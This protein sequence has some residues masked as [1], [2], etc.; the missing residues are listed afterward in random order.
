MG[1][2]CCWWQAK[3][4]VAVVDNI[5]GDRVS[6]YCACGGFRCSVSLS[7]FLFDEMLGILILFCCSFGTK[8]K[9]SS[10]TTSGAG[11]ADNQGG[12]S[13]TS[14]SSVKG[15]KPSATASAGVPLF[16]GVRT[17]ADGSQVLFSNGSTVTYRN[18]HGGQ[19]AYD[20]S[21]PLLNDAQ[22]WKWED[23]MFGVNLGGW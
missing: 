20:P 7:L 13:T 22:P 11:A 1:A 4:A 18:R 8:S 10:T 9:D 6:S 5:R 17:G 2:R 12:E 3:T 15:S 23:R 19:W 14:P 16:T 21:N